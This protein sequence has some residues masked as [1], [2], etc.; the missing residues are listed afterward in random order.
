M[1][2]G[3]TCGEVERVVCWL[4][5][6]VVLGWVGRT[7]LRVERFDCVYTC[8]PTGVRC[9]TG[10]GETVVVFAYTSALLCNGL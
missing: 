2:K 1:W 9:V 3:C 4:R 7:V 6:G 5:I 10:R 8:V